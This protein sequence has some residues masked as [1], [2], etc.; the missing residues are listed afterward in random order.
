M[1]VYDLPHLAA[2]QKT[3]DD[4]EASYNRGYAAG[5]KEGAR[6]ER[7]WFANYARNNFNVIGLEREFAE[8]EKELA[9]RS[10]RAKPREGKRI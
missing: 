3:L 6:R 10:K 5:L 8:F 7:R 1:S 2:I 4:H 9:T